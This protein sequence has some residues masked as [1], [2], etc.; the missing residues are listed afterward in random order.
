[1]KKFLHALGILVAVVCAVLFVVGGVIALLLFNLERGLFDATIYARAMEEQNLYE[2]LPHVAA[3]AIVAVMSS[4]P[5]PLNPVACNAESQP[6]ALIACLQND[7]GSVTYL[8]LAQN[9]RDPDA[10]ELEIVRAC[11]DQAGV[12]LPVERQRRGGPPGF[13]TNLTANDWEILLVAILPPD[14]LRALTDQALRGIFAVLNNEADQASLS[15][16]GLKQRLA[17]EDGYRA[18]LQLMRAQPPCTAAQVEEILA[19]GPRKAELC[20]PSDAQLASMEVSL[21]NGLWEA[22]DEIPAEVPLL[23]GV[24]A[25]AGAYPPLALARFIMRIS[26]LVPLGLLMV[27]TLFAVRTLRGW[28]RWWGIPLLITGALG[29]LL[30]LTLQP[31]FRLTFTALMLQAFPQYLPRGLLD[32]GADLL[33]A[34]LHALLEPV[35]LQSAI[36]TAVGV[37]LLIG[38]FFAPREADA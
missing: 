8:E 5:C 3:E 1:M 37:T 34:L 31:L 29:V 24:S 36:L 22:A 25:V 15:L 2:R 7:L 35:A 30:A 17:G 13:M 11:Y 20:N 38:S 18:L 14:E 10:A 21:R 9:R 6:P 12:P 33:G 23:P 16:V 4:D 26:P 19:A 27:I 32:A 28:L